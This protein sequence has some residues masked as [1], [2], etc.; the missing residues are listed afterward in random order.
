[1]LRARFSIVFLQMEW[2]WVSFCFFFFFNVDFWVIFICWLS[3]ES[4]GTFMWQIKLGTIGWARV[5]LTRATRKV[6][7][8]DSPQ[9]LPQTRLHAEFP[10]LPPPFP[11]SSPQGGRGAVGSWLRDGWAPLYQSCT[12]ENQ[13]RKHSHHSSI[14]RMYALPVLLRS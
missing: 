7:P 4:V 11:G 3:V 8:T 2:C 1:M 14:D 12:Q 13:G 9:S 6:A 10:C 5:E